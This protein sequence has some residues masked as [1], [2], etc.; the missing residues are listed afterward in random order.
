MPQ[1]TVSKSCVGFMA[2]KNVDNETLVIL[3]PRVIFIM[4]VREV[5]SYV[6]MVEYGDIYCLILV[7]QANF[8][9][10]YSCQSC[11]LKT[12]SFSLT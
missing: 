10:K 8:I 9:D 4:S 1:Q 6:H 12:I 3:D 2:N 5:E 11:I 7:S